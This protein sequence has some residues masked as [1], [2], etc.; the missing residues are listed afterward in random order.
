MEGIVTACEG[1]GSEA[2]LHLQ[3]GD[4][5]FAARVQPDHGAAEDQARH[6][7]PGHGERPLL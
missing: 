6:P 2:I 3:T 4:G 1:L 5:E 7:V